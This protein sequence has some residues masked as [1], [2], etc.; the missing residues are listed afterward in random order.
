[1]KKIII[2]HESYAASLFNDVTTFGFLV[3]VFWINQEYLSSA[4]PTWALGVLFLFFVTA[5]ITVEKKTQFT[6]KKDAIAAI[7]DFYASADPSPITDAKE[8]AE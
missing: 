4:I 5:K 8:G 1:M 3:G 2:V 6:N 7:E